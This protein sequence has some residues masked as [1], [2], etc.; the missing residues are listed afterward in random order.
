[1]DLNWR[2]TSFF[3]GNEYTTKTKKNEIIRYSK[4]WSYTSEITN[5][6]TKIELYLYLI[7]SIIKY[8]TYE[9][10]HSV[11]IKHFRST[12]KCTFGLYSMEQILSDKLMVYLFHFYFF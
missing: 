12:L 5:I 7:F 8:K 6:K 3:E 10:Y 4:W 2:A 1:M 9:L 11:K